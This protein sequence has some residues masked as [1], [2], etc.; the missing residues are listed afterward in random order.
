MT[1]KKIISIFVICAM[2]LTP[3][4]AS[5]AENI[6]NETSRVSDIELLN[7]LGV[8]TGYEDGNLHPDWSIT[9]MEFAAIIIRALGY[10]TGI[11]QMETGFSDVPA[12]LW[13]SG[14]VKMAY[15]LGIVSG[16]GDGT[17][18]PNNKITES[19]S[20][21][22][23]V[24]A[25]G[26]SYWAE[27]N[28]G[29]PNGYISMGS[30]LDILESA[31]DSKNEATRG[32][33][34]AILVNA[35]E[36]KIVHPEEENIADYEDNILLRLNISVRKGT[37]SA[38]Y[39]ASIAEELELR[40]N[41]VIVSGE[42]YK[43]NLVISRE[44]VGSNVKIYV[45]DYNTDDALIVGI[46][47]DTGTDTLT[48]YAEDIENTTTLNELVYCNENG[49]TR[50]EALEA[51][52]KISYN[53]MKIDNSADYTDSRLKPESGYVKLIDT[54][55]NGGYDT[56]VVMDYKTY[57][58]RSVSE[59]V[60]SDIYGGKVDIDEEAVVTVKL[61]NA[62]CGFEEI[63]ADDVLSAAVSL[64]GSLID[65]II[66]RDSAEGII[67]TYEND[68]EGEYYTLD[69]G[70][71]YS[72]TSSYV[73][74]LANRYSAAERLELGSYMKL[75][76]DHFGR[77]AVAEPGEEKERDCF[78]GYMVDIAEDDGIKNTVS[79]KILGHE[80]KFIYL[81]TAASKKIT[82]GR[83]EGENYEVSKVSPDVIY[84][85]IM[86]EGALTK[87]MIS[88]VLN[89]DGEIK[90]FY[91]EDENTGSEYF[92]MDVPRTTQDINYHTIDGKYYWDDDTVCFHIP[93]NGKNDGAL[94]SGKCVEYFSGEDSLIMELWDVE[95]D[96][97]VNCIYYSDTSTGR[98]LETGSVYYLDYV[99]S[100]VMLITK[101]QNITNDEGVDYK[102][103][104]GWE[105]KKLV[106][107]LLSDSLSKNSSDL[108]PGVII[109]YTTN[110]QQ[111]IYAEK[112][113]DDVVMMV[114]AVLFDCNDYN[115][116]EFM[117]YDYTGNPFTNSRIQFGHT[118]ITRL[119]Y[120]L[121]RFSEGDNMFEIHAGTTVYIY[122]RGSKTVTKGSV[123][124]LSEN[125]QVFIRTRYSNM[126][127]IVIL[128][129]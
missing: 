75:Y 99:N 96:G 126:R 45:K 74:A 17:F 124:D 20:I 24:A 100:P 36:T 28:G 31:V 16:Y 68:G 89:S 105:N 43:T 3:C 90:E 108:R 63:K 7:M 79:F 72:L 53:G 27:Q 95:S 14:Y 23:I 67:E 111:T 37:L 121:I 94:S 65:I 54:D 29:Y 8:F 93:S 116:G 128:K 52:I 57:V 60:I 76:L 49:R 15:D 69:D 40:E 71:E 13:G 77:V 4:I 106:R 120:P 101:V 97:Y 12:S 18:R 98:E 61:D 59:S 55:R 104:E 39:G 30:R 58:V 114:Y 6:E 87:Q 5:Y 11:G 42:L 110:E 19:E 84:D 34:A 66:C 26:Y 107:T 122:S 1:L 10:D 78:Y 9:R 118:A 82:F 86:E 91:L 32:Y 62:S 25:L 112:S 70:E 73:N 81:A 115:A 125:S 92:S 102:V 51:N 117:M 109:Q 2:C 22:M 35:L 50:K 33:V 88:Y 21:K 41:E 85:K 129:D 47:G 80:N 46:V 48:V 103:V 119:D 44:F 123:A 127:E 38:I 113:E 64:D 56:A 83:M